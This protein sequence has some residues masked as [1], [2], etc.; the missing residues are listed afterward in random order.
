MKHLSK[1]LLLLCVISEPAS[2]TNCMNQKNLAAENRL[3]R[4]RAAQ[5]GLLTVA[6]AVTIQRKR[7]EYVW[8]T[9][10]LLTNLWVQETVNNHNEQI[11]TMQPWMLHH[12]EQ[13]SIYEMEEHKRQ[14][15]SLQVAI[16]L[17]MMQQERELLEQRVELLQQVRAAKEEAEKYKNLVRQLIPLRQKKKSGAPQQND[18]QQQ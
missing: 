5:L 17:E 12:A 18:N 16:E 1:L 2:T 15:R 3:L 7:H 11:L 13:W 6:Q 4:T 10:I 9:G 8:A 14:E